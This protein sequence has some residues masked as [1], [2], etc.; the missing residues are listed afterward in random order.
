MA[1]RV[2][3]RI[4]EGPLRGKEQGIRLGDGLRIDAGQITISGHDA[5]VL[6]RARD[7][8]VCLP[9][10]DGQV[11]RHHCLLEVNP[12]D[13]QIRDFGSLNGTFV[14]GEKIGSRDQGQTPEEGQ[15]RSH[16]I[17]GLKDGDKVRVGG[18]TLAFTTE[19]DAVC[20][21]C[22]SDIAPQDQPDCRW[23]GKT[24][25]CRSCRQQEA[26]R[27]QAGPRTACADCGRAIGAGGARWGGRR[28]D[29]HYCQDCWASGHRNQAPARERL[30]PPPAQC[31]KCGKNVEAELGKGCRGDYICEACRQQ[32]EEDPAELLYCMLREAGLIEAGAAKPRVPGYDIGDR[33]GKG[34]CGAVYR[35]VEKTSGRTVA[36]KVMLAKVAV[37]PKA[38]ADFL[39]EIETTRTLSHPN[40][41]TLITHGA[42]GAVFYF[43]MEYCPQGSVGALMS[44]RGGRL[45][46]A[47]A[48][49]LILH[50]LEGLAYCHRQGIVHR[51]LKPDNILLQETGGRLVAKISDLGLAKSF[52]TAGFSGMTVTGQ[53]A[54][55][56]QFMPR[57]Q[58][59]HFRHVKPVSDVWSM[60]ATVY[61]MLTGRLPHDFPPSKDPG[62]VVLR[63][64]VIPVRQRDPALEPRVAQV[65]DRALAPRPEDRYRD[66]G[67]LRQAFAA[68][69]GAG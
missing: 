31:K 64:D 48:G 68:A 60:A 15:Q 23:L 21:R 58:L 29:A 16:R 40:V 45:S 9:E 8:Q 53:Y 3:I 1:K 51:D 56:F 41:I 43:V 61:H 52:E 24:F 67:E 4:I 69:L 7:C 5:L 65:I 39:R 57:E 38:R 66:G 44:R 42:A 2:K 62:E 54:G 19:A 27:A 22:G 13:V 46:L 6:G 35:A 47:E 25:L 14:N 20:D 37:S 63:G 10:D 28:G 12:P 59:T 30:R 32:A 34:G 11:S 17:V 36:V 49:P 50:A 55:T 33:L 18:T 26:D